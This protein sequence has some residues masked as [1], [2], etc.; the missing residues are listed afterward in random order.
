MCSHCEHQTERLVGTWLQ[1]QLN[2]RI[3]SDRFDWCRRTKTGKHLPFDFV[4]VYNN[5]YI[6]IEVDGC[7][8]FRNVTGWNSI[9]DMIRARDVYKA[10]LAIQRGYTVIRIRQLGI[11]NARA[12]ITAYLNIKLLPHIVAARPGTISYVEG[13]DTY[14]RHY[15]DMQL[16]LDGIAPNK[17]IEDDIGDFVTSS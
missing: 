13:P 2:L 17:L 5:V 8:H 4:V 1:H 7:Q 10:F 16:R 6:I 3:L 15:D 12:N 9:A 14:L 11:W